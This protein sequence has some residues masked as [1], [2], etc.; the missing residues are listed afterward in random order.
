MFRCIILV[1]AFIWDALLDR[2]VPGLELPGSCRSPDG[3]IKDVLPGP[4]SGFNAR[5]RVHEY[6]GGES[7]IGDGA[8]YWSNFKCVGI[9]APTPVGFCITAELWIAFGCKVIMPQ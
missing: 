3:A 2:T 4:D 1:R 8:V 6:G 9:H 7:V 5:T